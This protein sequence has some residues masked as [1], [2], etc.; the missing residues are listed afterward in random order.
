M[1]DEIIALSDVMRTEP[2]KGSSHGV[3][4]EFDATVGSKEFGHMVSGGPHLE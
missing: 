4:G 1:S 3:V 2:N